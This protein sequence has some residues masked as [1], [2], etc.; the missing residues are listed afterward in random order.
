MSK[1]TIGLVAA[2]AALASAAALSLLVTSGN[3]TSGH[4]IALS[5]GAA[6]AGA[7]TAGQAK[8]DADALQSVK[9]ANTA[10]A[11]GNGPRQVSAAT[12]KPVRSV[13]LALPVAAAKVGSNVTGAIRVLDTTGKTVAP[14][15]N[16]AV[17]FQQ[18]RGKDFV[19][20]ADGVTDESGLFAV[21]FTSTVNFTWRAQLTPATGAKLYSK[22]VVSIA[23]AG[24]ASYSFRVDPVN[25]TSAHLEIANSATPTKWVALK[26]ILVPETGVVVQT[27]TFPKPGTWLLRGASVSNVT[28]GAGYTTSLTII[29]G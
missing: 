15:A 19:T 9:D 18:K 22:N 5:A 26:N 10:K 6:P 24:S 3:G 2:S 4:S 23:S 7:V 25:K 8:I 14:V 27:A 17:A 12:A 20:I 28:N 13:T 1:R 11:A 16:A 29:V 21:A